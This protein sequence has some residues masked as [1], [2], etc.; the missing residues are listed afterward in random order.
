MSWKSLHEE[1]VVADLH[2]HSVLKNFLFGRGLSGK[3][4]RFLTGF[5]KRSFWPF[6]E[7]SN[8]PLIQQGGTNI[9][10]STCYV[11]EVQWVDDL[12]LI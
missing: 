6:S 7:R 1:S 3:K 10:L 11:P 8:F 5:F 2:N 12:S 9:V 4:P